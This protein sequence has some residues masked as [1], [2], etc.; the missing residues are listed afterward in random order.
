M[1]GQGLLW[2]QSLKGLTLELTARRLTCRGRTSSM[3]AYISGM[4]GNYLVSSATQSKENEKEFLDFASKNF[5][6]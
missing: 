6:L 2:K 3:E 1:L 4:Q 5:F